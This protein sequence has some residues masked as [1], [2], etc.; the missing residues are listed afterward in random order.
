MRKMTLGLLVEFI[1]KLLFHKRF[2]VDTKPKQI[3]GVHRIILADNLFRQ[4]VFQFAM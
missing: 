1:D 4:A 2:L 3:P